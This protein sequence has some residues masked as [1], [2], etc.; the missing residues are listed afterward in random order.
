MSNIT[1]AL[2]LF[3]DLVREVVDVNT[4][5]TWQLCDGREGCGHEAETIMATEQQS[6]RIQIPSTS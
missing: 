2:G 1:Q 4:S 5:A 3:E 6:T